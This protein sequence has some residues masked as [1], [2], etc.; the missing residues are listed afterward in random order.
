MMPTKPGRTDI[1]AISEPPLVGSSLLPSPSPNSLPSPVRTNVGMSVGSSVDGIDVGSL[2]S[3]PVE[4]H[5]SSG[6]KQVPEG[7]WQILASSLSSVGQ[8]E[9]V[10]CA[11]KTKEKELFEHHID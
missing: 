10:E 8:P 9:Q 5:P 2:V 1:M 7:H 3:S 4:T 6:S 11:F